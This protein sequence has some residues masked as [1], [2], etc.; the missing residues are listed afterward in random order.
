MHVGSEIDG[1]RGSREQLR[2][3]EAVSISMATTENRH[4]EV[5]G[6]SC[7]TLLG[8]GHGLWR[9]LFCR[10]WLHGVLSMNLI[11]PKQAWSLPDR[12]GTGQTHRH[13]HRKQSQWSQIIFVSPSPAASAPSIAFL[14]LLANTVCV[15][16][17]ARK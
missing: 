12:L 14:P 2:R 10:H 6:G 8:Q 9:C 3:K 5:P 15:L 16:E 4:F 11:Q 13:M 1:H 7:P 17:A